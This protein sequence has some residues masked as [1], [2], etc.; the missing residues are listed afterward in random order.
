VHEERA[1]THSPPRIDPRLP[2][3]CCTRSPQ[4]AI[5]STVIMPRTRYRAPMRCRGTTIPMRHTS[6]VLSGLGPY[7]CGRPS[8]TSPDD[9]SRRR[10][11][12]RGVD[13]SRHGA[14]GHLGGSRRFT[15]GSPQ[16]HS[17]RLEQLI[18]EV[19]DHRSMVSSRG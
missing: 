1:R 5:A 3:P 18:L 19:F 13:L 7:S 15:A 14:P 17:R 4:P 10:Y 16:E 12:A 6:P 11:V 9:V 2:T 8:P